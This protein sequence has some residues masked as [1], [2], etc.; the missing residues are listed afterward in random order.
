MMLPN[1]KTWLGALCM[2]YSKPDWPTEEIIAAAYRDV[3]HIPQEHLEDIGQYIRCN[4]EYWPR[5][6]S[7]AMHKA[8]AQVLA[9]ITMAEKRER[10]AQLQQQRP[11]TTPEEKAQSQS[12]CRELLRGLAT[13][14]RPPWAGQPRRECGYPGPDAYHRG[15]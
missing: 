12:R 11:E 13:G 3:R 15:R 14:V 5:S 2:Y 1:F 7:S 9:D 8:H 6:L 10:E 4:Y